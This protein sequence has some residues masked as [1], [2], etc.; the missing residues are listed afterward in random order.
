MSK[1][2][3]PPRTKSASFKRALAALLCAALPCSSGPAAFAQTAALPLAPAARGGAFVP[4]IAPIL[5]H[6]GLDARS[7]PTR[8]LPIVLPGLPVL[9]PLEL[10]RPTAAAKELPLPLEKGALLALPAPAVQAAAAPVQPGAAKAALPAGL[11]ETLSG[12]PV[13]AQSA[14]TAPAAAVRGLKILSVSAEDAGRVFDGSLAPLAHLDVAA[15]R[16]RG[17]RTDADGVVEVPADARGPVELTFRL[18]GRYARVKDA[19]GRDLSVKVTARPGERLRVVFDPA[20]ADENARAQLA[21]YVHA[22]KAHDALRAAGVKSLFLDRTA[23]ISVNGEEGTSKYTPLFIGLLLFVLPIGWTIPRLF[24]GRPGETYASSAVEE[25]I[26]HEYGHLAHDATGGLLG[27]WGA[28]LG[29]G[30]GDTLAMY[31]S[32]QPLIARGYVRGDALGYI[33]TGENDYRYGGRG[34]EHVKGQ[35][36]MGFTWKLRAALVASLGETQGAAFAAS[37][38]LPV[39]LMKPRSILRAVYA[40]LQRDLG[41]DGTAPH[42]DAIAAAAAA[43]GIH[44]RRP[45]EAGPVL[46]TDAGGAP[47]WSLLRGSAPFRF[48]QSASR[49]IVRTVSRR[50]KAWWLWLLAAGALL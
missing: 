36:W 48:L 23:R 28:A 8:D 41:P 24:F 13:A 35:A 30:W 18:R 44:L 7:V 49:R 33:R 31:V 1:A 17:L 50:A 2:Q 40:V 37:L 14:E 43:H 21:A 22:T 9:P 10:S 19:E 4:S 11:G 3:R 16:G 6:E 26:Y 46:W 32:G 20:D 45:G 25:M 5:F 39:L 34:D 12:A 15:S 38:V 29:E 42:F 27:D 47:W